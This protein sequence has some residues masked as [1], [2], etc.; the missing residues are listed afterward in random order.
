[1]K[2]T[3]YE[4]LEVPPDADG[5][6][7]DTAFRRLAAQ[8]VADADDNRQ[9]LLKEAHDVLSNPRQ[10]AAYDATLARLAVAPA[11]EAE[12][13]AANA[14]S[15]AADAPASRASAVRA[16]WIVGL[17]VLL[18]AGLWLLQRDAAPEPVSAA[19]P[20]PD[21]AA[22][23]VEPVAAP[24]AG[25]SADELFALLAPRVAQLL[26]ADEKG[27]PLRSGSGVVVEGPAIVT[28]CRVTRGSAQVR[29]RIGGRLLDARL[30]LADELLDL[31]RLAVP[32]LA[33]APVPLGSATTLRPGQKVFG[34]GSPRGQGLGIAEGLFLDFRDTG[35]GSHVRSTVPIG[36]GSS[37]GGLFD[38]AGRLV[39]ILSF[40]PELDRDFALAIPADRIARIEDRPAPAATPE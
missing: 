20:P 30:E 12:A 22:P 8:M 10:R 2:K 38:A 39:G 14:D 35:A 27:L 21:A 19:A 24:S 11:P 1:M 3:L 34:L 23:A 15:T 25:R 31:C 37:G 5:A 7:I 16:L 29:A 32:E 6:R 26:V 9:V 18:A 33:A 4:I 36:P 28:T 40:R 13:P 17:L